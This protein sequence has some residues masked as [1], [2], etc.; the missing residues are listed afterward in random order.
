MR[1]S[2]TGGCKLAPPVFRILQASLE[3]P[4]RPSTGQMIGS[5]M[6]AVEFSIKNPRSDHSTA[7]ILLPA[8]LEERF[9]PKRAESAGMT[10]CPHSAALGLQP[11]SEPKPPDHR[12]LHPQAPAAATPSPSPTADSIDPKG[13]PIP[14]PSHSGECAYTASCRL[15]RQNK[16]VGG[17]GMGSVDSIYPKIDSIVSGSPSTSGLLL[18]LHLECYAAWR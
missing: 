9:A 15:V 2:D 18:F 8:W 16:I 3:P 14:K 10:V 7:L 11:V 13:E 1:H 5:R 17:F 12:S 4:P 6:G